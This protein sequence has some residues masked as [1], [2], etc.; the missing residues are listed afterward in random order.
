[1]GDAVGARGAVVEQPALEADVR[2]AVEQV[3]VGE[4]DERAGA[5][6]V[7]VALDAERGRRAEQVRLLEVDRARVD[8]AFAPE[9]D[10]RLQGPRVPRA[11]L[12]IHH[13]VLVAC[14]ADAHLVDRG[15]LA[16]QA[17]GLVD[18]AHRD[19][20]AGLEEQN[21]S[22][23]RRLRA[24]M[25]RVRRAKEDVV[26]LRVVGIEDVVGEDADLADAGAG[27]LELREG[28]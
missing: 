11:H 24:D 12:E 26:F 19:R 9:A 2:P 25:D 7:G 18:H 15:R 14:R 5:V 1:V 28:R 16:D 8:A 6:D 4:L 27:R 23:Q 17:L 21:A 20:L 13:P 10:A 22:D 3:V